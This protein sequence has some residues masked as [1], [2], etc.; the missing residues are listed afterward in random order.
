MKPIE[1]PGLDTLGDERRWA[2]FSPDRLYRYALGACWDPTLPT[3][4]IF[5]KNPSKASH[6]KPDP[7]FTK[8]LGFARLHGC[9]SVLLR[10]LS[11]L[12]ATN[13]RDLA[14]ADDPI[15]PRNAELLRLKFVA[16]HRVAA[17]GA[18]ETKEIALRLAPS[19]PAA[20]D[21]CREVFRL[22]KDGHPWHPLYLPWSARV[23]T[24]SEAKRAS[25]GA[26]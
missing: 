14:L 16:Q 15:G 20:K 13:P 3:F 12:V 2:V 19:L 23:M 6:L 24:W 8:V 21:D 1:L 10:N 18:F 4:S 11:A 9:G 22:T 5:M 7:T 26:P 17:W 25:G